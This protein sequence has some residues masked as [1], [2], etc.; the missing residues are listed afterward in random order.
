M[1]L[2]YAIYYHKDDLP[3]SGITPVAYLFNRDTSAVVAGTCSATISGISLLTVAA[4]DLPV[5]GV[6][7]GGA[8]LGSD[9]RYV[10]VAINETPEPSYSIKKVVSAAGDKVQYYQGAELLFTLNRTTAGTDIVWS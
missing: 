5:V 3:V 8:T 10:P 1:A 7:D 2:K 6:V 9:E 4:A